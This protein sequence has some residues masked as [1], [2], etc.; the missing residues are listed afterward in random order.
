MVC[1][2]WVLSSGL[3]ASAC[4]ALNPAFDLEVDAATDTA[5][6]ADTF[7]P[8]STATS[9]GEG[10]QSDSE[11]SMDVP[12][13]G[14]DQCVPDLVALIEDCLDAAEMS[15]PMS[16]ETGAD[17]YWRHP[18][19][20]DLL[21]YCT[22]KAGVAPKTWSGDEFLQTLGAAGLGIDPA[23]AYFD[24]L[25][26]GASSEV[27]EFCEGDL[28]SFETNVMSLCS[29]TFEAASGFVPYVPGPAIADP[30][31]EVRAAFLA[32]DCAEECYRYFEVLQIPPKVA[33][34][35]GGNAVDEL[36]EPFH[37]T[38]TPSIWR[39]DDPEFVLGFPFAQPFS[40]VRGL[41][42]GQDA[43]KSVFF[44]DQGITEDCEDYQ[45]RAFIAINHRRRVLLKLVQSE[46][47]PL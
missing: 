44:I 16:P 11:A 21:E 41:I 1:R 30:L 31:M 37:F 28:P 35:V 23:A 5:A 33:P 8:T 6:D 10:T 34:T 32:N 24:Y 26:N 38:D 29:Q 15:K 27:Y 14:A 17:E 4:S 39:S 25:C 43:W 36:L 2:A 18:V 7:A 13:P 19:K 47:S 45:H 3:V 42:G 9:D 22:S 20:S 12:A 40:D 46:C